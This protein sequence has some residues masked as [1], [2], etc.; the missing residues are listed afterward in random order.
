MVRRILV[1]CHHAIGDVIM[2]FPALKR[3]REAFPKAEIHM[4]CGTKEEIALIRLLGIIDRYYVLNVKTD[5][6]YRI[7]KLC[8]KL[9]S[10]KYELGIALGQSRRGLD[11]LLL[12][13]GGCGKV[14][15]VANKRAV[16]PRYIQVDV[17]GI[18]HRVE[19]HM[20]CVEKAVR[21]LGAGTSC[22][23]GC[24]VCPHTLVFPDMICDENMVGICI[25]TGSFFYR[26]P[27]RKIFYN[28][29]EWPVQNWMELA[30]HLTEMGKKVVLFGGER[31]A[32]RLVKYQALIEQYGI[33]NLAGVYSLVESVRN[34]ASCFTVV[35][36]DTG[37]MHA[38]AALDIYTVT[39]FGP[40]D[41]CVAGA[42]SK[43]ARFVRAKMSCSP[44][45]GQKCMQECTSHKCMRKISVSQVMEQIQRIE[46]HSGQIHR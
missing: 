31:E 36:A 15:S 32:K 46:K 12:K 45:Y 34:L 16:D 14:I 25:G 29:K 20:A 5:G 6:G 39:L 4:I 10:G 41:P 13:A 27:F 35:G 28:V 7:W 26:K 18:S 17:S 30:V 11:V 1:E 33:K 19:Q 37:L 9:R 3:L 21:L 44:C 43:K 22:S 38:A 23:M 24:G 42:Y 8:G 40:T 2:T